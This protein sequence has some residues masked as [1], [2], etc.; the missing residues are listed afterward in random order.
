LPKGEHRSALDEKQDQDPRA[1]SRS[2]NFFAPFC[3]RP[4]CYDAVRSSCRRQARYCSD[5]CRQALRRVRDRERKW[6]HR[7]RQGPPPPRP[8]GHPAGRSGRRARAP[9]AS[10][11]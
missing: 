1:W 4:G 7:H 2:K 3:D 9:T 5:G 8:A 11:G 10:V 6:L